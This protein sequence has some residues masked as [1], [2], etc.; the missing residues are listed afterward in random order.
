MSAV[1]GL[2]AS[3]PIAVIAIALGGCSIPLGS[4][5][6]SAEQQEEPAQSTASANIA[7][8]GR[9]IRTSPDDPTSYNMRGL[10][11]AQAGKFDEALADFN[12]AQP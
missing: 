12:K 9:S 5:T 2:R 11:L 6:P 3:A 1:L 4:L 8:L 7:W 10:A